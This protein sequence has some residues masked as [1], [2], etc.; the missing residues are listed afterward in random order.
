MTDEVRIAV[1]ATLPAAVAV[2]LLVVA[3]VIRWR[4]LRGGL[5]PAPKEEPKPSPAA[6]GPRLSIHDLERA[7]RRVLEYQFVLEAIDEGSPIWFGE[8]LPNGAWRATVMMMPESDAILRAARDETQRK[9]AEQLAV[10]E[11]HGIDTSRI[12]LRKEGAS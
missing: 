10:L 6:D 8:R 1:G 4:R 11:R 9:M 2:I 3:L 12:K 5:A 7:E